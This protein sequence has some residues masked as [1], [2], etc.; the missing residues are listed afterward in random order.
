ME[1]FCFPSFFR[2]WQQFDSEL[3]LKH[4]IVPTL[5]IRLTS[6]SVD[7]V[8]IKDKHHTEDT[9]MMTHTLDG[10]KSDKETIDAML[11]ELSLPRP[12]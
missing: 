7:N 12:K 9:I 6:V 4:H 2:I 3:L 1:R 11:K 10:S 8:A 5:M